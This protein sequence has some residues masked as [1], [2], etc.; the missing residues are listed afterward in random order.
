MMDRLSKSENAALNFTCSILLQVI[1]A[2]IGLFLPKLMI[3]E[4]GSDV[5]GLIT[6]IT[7][8]LSYISLVEGG[9]GAIFRA[10]LYKPLARNDNDQLS[11]V[12]VTQKRFYRRLGFFFIL[13]VVILSI[14]YPLIVKTDVDHQYI[15][16]LI[17][18]ICVG[19]ALE[20]FISLPYTALITADQH[21]RI[22]S[23][24][25][26][27]TITINFFTSIILIRLHCSF[28]AVKTATC[29][30]MTAKPLL[31][32]L[33][34]KKNYKLDPNAI[35][36]DSILEQRWNGMVHHIAYFLHSNID[37][38][39]LT[40][41]VGTGAVSV[42]SI[43][44][45]I[46][47]GIQKV[48]SAF[49]SGVSAGIGHLLWDSDEKR[50]NEVVDE[51]EFTYGMSATV[52]FSITI[53][54]IVPFVRIYSRNISDENYI[55]PLFAY[56]LVLAQWLYCFRHMYSLISDSA[57][58]FKKTQYGAIMESGLN[59][60]VSLILLFVFDSVEMKL[61]GIA[62][63]T[64]VGMLS[65][66]LF[67][68]VFL[69]RN[70]LK[71]P[72]WKPF[73]MLLSSVFIMIITVLITNIWIP[74]TIDTYTKWVTI[75]VVVSVTSLVSFVLVA[76]FL[77]KRELMSLCRRLSNLWRKINGKNR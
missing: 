75:A 71:R 12:V 49:S 64:L 8:F 76:F 62:F 40:V 25:S 5:N 50:I 57:N 13:Y 54:L 36:D 14:I 30:I 10:S 35:P 31:Y 37:I 67:E 26:I 22:V 66:Y 52:L 21:V 23:V 33:Y 74:S 6:S 44:F 63:G 4:F 56:T 38:M 7:H 41:F 34:V 51:Y 59:L 53:V 9:I 2:I 20:Y 69:S 3:G 58:M 24:V 11:R 70:V 27:L 43:Y 65:R 68:I 42:Y 77:Y 48:L 45:A 29:V 28:V 60:I 17:L 73:K 16:I 19:T 47:S 72:I 1:T 15:V 61:F 32:S 46:I 39:L 55:A 18:I